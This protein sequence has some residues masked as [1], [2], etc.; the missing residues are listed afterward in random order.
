MR[1]KYEPGRERSALITNNYP[2]IHYKE[3][4]ES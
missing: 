1:E 4:R 3:G 2:T